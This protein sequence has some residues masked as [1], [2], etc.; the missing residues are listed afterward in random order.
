[1]HGVSKA[2]DTARYSLLAGLDLYS[3]TGT[4]KGGVLKIKPSLMKSGKSKKSR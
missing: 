2:V 3:Q 1:M 4:F